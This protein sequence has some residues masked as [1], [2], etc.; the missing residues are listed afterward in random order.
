[1]IQLDSIVLIKRKVACDLLKDV[2]DRVKIPSSAVNDLDPMWK[3]CSIQ[4]HTSTKN[5]R[6][7]G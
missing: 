6:A 4:K 1:M 5:I 3:G 2:P 7:P